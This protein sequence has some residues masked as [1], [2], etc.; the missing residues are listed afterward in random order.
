MRPAI[1]A[2]YLFLALSAAGC[3][4]D[5]SYYYLMGLNEYE[6]G[7]YSVAK[8]CFRVAAEKN[9]E[10]DAESWRTY[11]AG[12]ELYGL[13]RYAEALEA[14][15]ETSE[16]HPEWASRE[17]LEK[18]HRALGQEEYK[19]GRLSEARRHFEAAMELDPSSP[20]AEWLK[21]IDKG[22]NPETPPSRGGDE[23]PAP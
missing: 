8:E 10:S 4:R 16:K 12:I 5:Y 20:A 14:L 21:K 6:L 23:E 17:W 13:G 15:K 2:A 3:G 9:P 11:M 18:T 1:F 19:L 22:I 7:R